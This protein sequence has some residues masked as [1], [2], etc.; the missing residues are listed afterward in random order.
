MEISNNF[1]ISRYKVAVGAAQG[2]AYLHHDCVRTILHRDVK[3]NNIL[4]DSR[5]ETYLADFGLARLMNSPTYHQAMSRVAGSY[6]YIAPEYWYTMKITEKS[7]V[8][9][10]DVVL[11]EIL[12]GRSAVESR[13]GDGLHIV[14]WVKKKMGSIKPAVTILDFKLRGLR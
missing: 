8:Y 12:R 10:Y 11:L 7:D 3:C 5:F 13:V 1:C 9:S 14:D 4:L 2:L 6:G